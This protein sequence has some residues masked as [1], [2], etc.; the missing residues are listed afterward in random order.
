M[1]GSP[2]NATYSL[3]LRQ[4]IRLHTSTTKMKTAS[5]AGNSVAIAIYGDVCPALPEGVDEHIRLV[6]GEFCRGLFQ[7]GSSHMSTCDP[8][9]LSIGHCC[10]VCAQEKR[11]LGGGHGKRAIACVPLGKKP[12]AAAGGQV[13]GA[14]HDGLL[15]LPGA[16]MRART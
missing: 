2:K 5:D 16:C 8:R 9:D 15:K 1:F 6:P 10:K 4:T 3:L 12:Q 11:E 13:R 7:S 14:C